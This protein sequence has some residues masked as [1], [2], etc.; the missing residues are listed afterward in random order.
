MSG[1]TPEQ[2]QSDGTLSSDASTAQEQPDSAG[3]GS[4][5]KA[6]SAGNGFLAM[7]KEFFVIGAT[8][9]VISL[10]IKTFLFQMFFIPSHSMVPTLT[11]GD[12]VVVSQL[13]PGLFD[14]KRGDVVVFKDPGGW[15]GDQNVTPSGPLM[16]AF[17]TTL[18]FVGV[19]P[20][21]T[22]EHLIKRIVGMPGDTV[23]CC[24]A[25][26]R[27][28]VNGAGVNEPYVQPGS[29]MSDDTFNVVV[30]PGKVWVMGDNRNSS[31]DSRFNRDKI[32]EGF[33][34]LD[35]VVGRATMV[36]WPIPRWDWLDNYTDRF[37]NSAPVGEPLPTPTVDASNT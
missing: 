29:D 18:T 12:R 7:L 27:L 32:D 22:G 31:F 15:L 17:K 14:L 35:L 11:K 3:K 16:K 21:D 10:A 4:A 24:D 28:V 5:K 36:A 13:T 34:D 33:V 19:L 26:A 25:Q 1:D 20:K 9:L 37:S 30:P 23:V 8:A 6:D 2:P